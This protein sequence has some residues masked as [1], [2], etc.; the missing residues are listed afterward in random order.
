ML[1]AGDQNFYGIST[2]V[3][4]PCVPGVGE[5]DTIYQVKPGGVASV[6]YTFA[7][8][9]SN[10]P[11]LNSPGSC[12]L[13]DLIVGT[14]GSLYGTCIYGG[15]GG[16]GSIFKIPLDGSPPNPTTLIS[17]GSVTGFPISATNRSRSLRAMTAIS[18][19]PTRW[20]FLS[21]TPRAM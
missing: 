7:G 6:F 15:N 16:N 8:T 2:S 1:Q 12:Q 4:L 5:C 18:T 21:S 10:S 11:S 3:E 17:F 9:N 20:E 13:T 14:D 19:S